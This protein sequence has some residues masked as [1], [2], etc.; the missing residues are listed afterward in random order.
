LSANFLLMTR[1]ALGI[2]ISILPFSPGPAKR[3]DELADLFADGSNMAGPL[4]T[5]APSET[6]A[7]EKL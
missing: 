2:S 3:L 5:S 7:G 1:S 6:R 4:L